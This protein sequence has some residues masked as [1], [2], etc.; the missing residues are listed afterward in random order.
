MGKL[1][2]LVTT[3]IYILFNFIFVINLKKI[4]KNFFKLNMI[5][6]LGLLTFQE[7]GIDLPGYK[8]MFEDFLIKDFK[9]LVIDKSPV[10]LSFRLLINIV[11][12]FSS[13]TLFFLFII[14]LINVVLLYSILKNQKDKLLYF[15]FYFIINFYF[16]MT[17]YLRQQLSLLFFLSGIFILHKRIRKY[18]FYMLSF[19]F[20]KS[21]I[22]LGVVVLCIKF[23]KLKKF[24]LRNM[25]YFFL[26]GFLFYRII[27]F[28]LL[29]YNGEN[30]YILYFKNYF[31]YFRKNT[32]FPTILHKILF[33][34]Y[35]G[36]PFFLNLIFLIIM[37]KKEVINNIDKI[38]YKMMIV[39]VYYC[40]FLLGLGLFSIGVFEIGMRST[41][42]FFIGNFYVIGNYISLKKNKVLNI[43]LFSL[44]VKFFTIFVILQIN[45]SI[46]IF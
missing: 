18:F 28:V 2:T 29:N 46:G 13:N 25:I 12:H 44:I 38:F 1:L 4:S 19:I 26:I 10:E 37:R 15:Y 30:F 33:I 6:L 22:I 14:S 11:K 21:S 41:Y 24:Y 7:L 17:N 39:G 3:E 9:S 8:K 35:I 23:F 36:Y 32:I 45:R 42:Y 20:H 43:I 40:S 27:Y 5:I 31:F 16:I 34:F